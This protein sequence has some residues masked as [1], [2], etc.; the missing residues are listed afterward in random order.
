VTSKLDAQFRIT[1]FQ[2]TLELKDWRRD[3][4]SGRQYKAVMGTVSILSALEATGMDLTNRESNW[5][6]V[7]E[8][9][10]DR[11]VFPGCQIMSIVNHETVTRPPE[12][13]EDYIL[14]AS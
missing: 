14:V 13:A 8:G 6:G 11:Y 3:P 10:R 7:V 1:G 4:V 5:L 9:D 2:G 12:V